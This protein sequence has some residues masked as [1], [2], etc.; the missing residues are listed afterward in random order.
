MRTNVTITALLLGALILPAVM[1]GNANQPELTDAADDVPNASVDVVAAW[2]STTQSPLTT[3]GDQTVDCL[4]FTI[5]EDIL[6]V[7]VKVQD[8]TLASPIADEDPLSTRYYYTIKFTPDAWGKEVTIHCMINYQDLAA[9][10][11]WVQLSVL[12]T[13]EVGI[14]GRGCWM[15]ASGSLGDAFDMG[16]VAISH[17]EHTLR[18]TLYEDLLDFGPGSTFSGLTVSTAIGSVNT[19]PLLRTTPADT[20]GVGSTFTIA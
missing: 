7:Y 19:P 16:G 9:A 11:L 18:V 14:V 4:L 15:P 8:F 10:G 5:C 1:A 20:T 3:T 13:P 12:A 2:F 6:R 17:T